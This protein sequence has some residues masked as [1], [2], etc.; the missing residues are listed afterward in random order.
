M[1]PVGRSG[2][3]GA[4]FSHGVVSMWSTSESESGVVVLVAEWLF[5]SVHIH[6]CSMW[7]WYLVYDV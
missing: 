3:V 2:I 5:A 1:Q 4:V 6:S 7:L